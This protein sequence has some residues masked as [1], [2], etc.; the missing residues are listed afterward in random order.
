M[1]ESPEE[2]ARLAVRVRPAVQR[3]THPTLVRRSAWLSELAG[4]PI[5]LVLENLQVTGSF[6]VR[7]AVASLELLGPRAAAGVLASSAGNHGL[8]LAHA[9]RAAGVP[10]T[11][12]VPSTVPKSK[13]AAMRALGA[14]VINAPH[15]G[16]D[17]TE[18]YTRARADELGGTFVSPFD[19]PAVIAGNGGTLALDLL[20]AR[21]DLAAIVA[22]CG[23]GGLLSG[24]GCVVA[25]QRPEVAVIGVN[26]AAS[27]AMWASRRDGRAHLECPGGP[28]IAEG[29]EGGV[30]ERTFA[31]VQATAADVLVVPESALR[32]ALVALA[33]HEHWIV[34]GAA[35]AGVAALLSGWRPPGPAAVVLTG[36]NVDW[37][38]VAALIAESATP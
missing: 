20:A 30:S 36:C 8:G 24:L 15:A 17:A 4:C 31:L 5:W 38:L 10:C 16:Y 9:A 11:V 29:L 6:K 12:V 7:G 21:P 35:A 28:T 13:D 1:I 33:R 25:A 23:G 34:E 18:A 26:S 2:I 14:R 19:D 3:A 37:P 22:P 27:P 32:S